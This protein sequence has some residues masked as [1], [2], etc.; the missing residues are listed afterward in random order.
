MVEKIRLPI[1]RNIGFL[2]DMIWAQIRYD[3]CQQQL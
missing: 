3:G 1:R 2:W